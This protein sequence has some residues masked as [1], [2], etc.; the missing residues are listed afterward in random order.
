MLTGIG[1]ALGPLLWAPFSEIYGRQRVF[2]GTYFAFMAFNA[3]VAGAPNIYGLLIL[4]FF[5]AAF[6][7]SPLTNAGG[8]IA[9]LFNAQERGLAVAIFSAAPF[10]GPVL[11]PIIGGFLG[12]TNGEFL[13][14]PLVRTI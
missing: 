11:G 4:R 10:M 8:V 12:M 9:D 6:G 2:F 1:F 13:P 3:G 5:A 14:F 7:S